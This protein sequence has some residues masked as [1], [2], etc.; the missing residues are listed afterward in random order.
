MKRLVLFFT[1]LTFT[2]LFTGCNN[3]EDK[4]QDKKPAVEQQIDDDKASDDAEPEVEDAAE[5]SGV[6]IEDS[7]EIPEESVE[8]EE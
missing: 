1:L 7:D 4:A 2:M 5:E 3:D 8:I 6:I